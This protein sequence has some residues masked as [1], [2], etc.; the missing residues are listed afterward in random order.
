MMTA[1]SNLLSQKYYITIRTGHYFRGGGLV[2]MGCPRHFFCALTNEAKR[3]KGHFRGK[4]DKNSCNWNS[5]C[6][7]PPPLINHQSLTRYIPPGNP[8]T[9]VRRIPPCLPAA[10]CCPWA[11]PHI[12]F[13][14]L[15]LRMTL[16][17]DLSAAVSADWR[18]VKQ[19]KA[20]FCLGT[21]VIDR[22]SPNW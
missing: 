7:S 8:G 12:I 11:L 5:K 9:G 19:T 1:N 21:M 2:Q 13:N 14:L 17:K 22:S 18:D 3:V 16:L 10:G 4:G 15:P 20:Q 6:I